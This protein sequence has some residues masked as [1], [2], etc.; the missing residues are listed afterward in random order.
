MLGKQANLYNKDT[1]HK[2]KKLEFKAMRF[3]M[4]RIRKEVAYGKTKSDSGQNA[5]YFLCSYTV[6][7]MIP[8]Y[9]ILSRYD[10]IDCSIMY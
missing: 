9:H 10:I 5:K 2:F 1:E 7:Y 6:N 8:C 3:A 4:D